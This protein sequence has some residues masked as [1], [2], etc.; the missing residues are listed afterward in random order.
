MINFEFNGISSIDKGVVVTKFENNDNLIS[1]SLVIGEKNRYRARENHFGTQY[2]QNYSFTLGIS[3]NLCKKDFNDYYFTSNEIKRIN[4]WLTSPHLPKLFKFINNDYFDE[5]IEFFV[6]IT[7]I[8]T[9]HITLPHEL[10]YTVQCD[11]PYGPKLFKFINNDY[12]DEP[13]EF[14]VTITEINTEHITL[15]HELIYTVQCD[16][17][18]GYTPL[19]TQKVVSNTIVP[20]RLVLTNNSDELEDYVYPTFKILPKSHSDIT[21]KNITDNGILK[22]KSLRNDEFYIDCQRLK[23]YDITNELLSFEDLGIS[24]V[25]SIYWPRL[26]S[27]QNTF[28]FQGDA[29]IEISWREPRKVGAF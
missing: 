16:S 2:D 12:F 10:I 5:P 15:P 22:I 14:F 13:I 3:K 11:S 25:D 4:S 9:E 19:I 18:Y 6:T 27:G 28:E 1:R 23:I 24:D 17:P 29:D 26:C 8:N 20:E 7:E 21:I